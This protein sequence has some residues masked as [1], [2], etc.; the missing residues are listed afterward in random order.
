MKNLVFIS[1]FI[2]TTLG[3]FL[4]ISSQ[5]RTDIKCNA[6]NL[7]K[8]QLSKLWSSR[9]IYEGPESLVFDSERGFI[10]ASNYNRNVKTGEEYGR[11]FIS[12]SDLN[13]EFVEKKWINNLTTPT[14]ICIFKNKLFIVERFGIVEFN[15]DMDEVERTYYLPQDG[16]L[17]DVAVSSDTSIFVTVSNRNRIYRIKNGVVEEWLKTDEIYRVNGIIY[18]QENLIVGI[19]GD[20]CLKSINISTKEIKVLGNVG[21]G[22]IDGVKKCSK[23]YL[24]SHLEGSIYLVDNKGVCSEILNVRNENISIADFEYVEEKNLIIIP[25]L[26]GN[27]IITYKI[28][29]G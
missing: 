19:N 12:K 1:V 15:L 8:A 10:Y 22:I 24:V 27:R 13:G 11:H 18:E 7:S 16:F 26:K 14:G 3:G 9:N 20:N 23:G 4:N 5:V 28:S 6:P 2:W 21:P 25:D 29:L 17:N